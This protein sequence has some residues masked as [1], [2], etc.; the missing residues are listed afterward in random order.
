MSESVHIVFG[1]ASRPSLS[2][3]GGTNQDSL[4]VVA[5]QMHDSVNN[6]SFWVAC[7]ADG[8]GS[9]HCPEMASS[10]AVRVALQEAF[11][12]E[13][14]LDTRPARM[15]VKANNAVIAAAAGRNWGTTL[16]CVISSVDQIYLG[17]V[18]DSRVILV[19]DGIGR[20]VTVDHTRL[21]ETMGVPVPSLDAVKAS[22]LARSLSK[23]LGEMPFDES[24]VYVPQAQYQPRPG[25]HLVI[26]SDGVWTE[27]PE[28]EMA[29]TVTTHAPQQ[30]AETLVELALYRD[31]TDDASAIVFFYPFDKSIAVS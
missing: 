31:P 19:R 8:M 17:H 14:S 11:S 18:G 6:C 22:P 12:A 25:D 10:L 15:I 1:T 30:A 23:S 9:L 2:R 26:C 29:D 21:A 3:E 13:F 28:R 20:C 4:G 5:V 16:T 27:I 7:L 24:Y